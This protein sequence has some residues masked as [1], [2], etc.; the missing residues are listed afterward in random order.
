LSRLSQVHSK[1]QR[2]IFKF[3]ESNHQVAIHLARVGGDVAGFF[4]FVSDI[5]VNLVMFRPMAKR[6]VRIIQLKGLDDFVNE[7]S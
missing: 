4:N 7:N 3:G 1:V 5:I 2:G 6:L